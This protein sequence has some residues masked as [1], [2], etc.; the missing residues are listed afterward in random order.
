MAIPRLNHDVCRLSFLHRDSHELRRTMH[1]LHVHLASQPGIAG[2]QSGLGAI[3]RRGV[4]R[5]WH[6]LRLIAPMRASPSR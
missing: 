1:T 6:R 4:C 3:G 2:G 5:A